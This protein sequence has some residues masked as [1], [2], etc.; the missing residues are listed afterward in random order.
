M[1][2]CHLLTNFLLSAASF[3]DKTIKTQGFN[4]D[5]DD[6]RK[7]KCNRNEKMCEA[8]TTNYNG[9]IILSVKAFYLNTHV[10]HENI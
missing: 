4:N 10:E 8:N 7:R 2:G 6:K 1:V 3:T 5:N 9:K